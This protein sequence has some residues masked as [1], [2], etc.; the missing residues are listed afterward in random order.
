MVKNA[1]KTCTFYG[2]FGSL[3]CGARSA[4]GRT[5]RTCPESVWTYLHFAVRVVVEIYFYC[6]Y[7]SAFVFKLLPFMANKDVYI[8][9]HVL[10]SIL[11][12]LFFLR[13]YNANPPKFFC[14][15]IIVSVI[16]V[17]RIVCSNT[18]GDIW[19]PTDQE[20]WTAAN[21]EC[22]HSSASHDASSTYT[23]TF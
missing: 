12:L 20:S 13:F 9:R 16:I 23:L 10:R 7:I 4:D 3:L 5:C 15:I 14:M 8:N 21:T 1:Y 18:L 6:T 2:Q 17:Y 19:K 11:S 22:L